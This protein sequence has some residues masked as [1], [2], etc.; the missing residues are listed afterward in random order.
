[1]ATDR[2]AGLGSIRWSGSTRNDPGTKSESTMD[3]VEPIDRNGRIITFYS[4]KGGVGRTMALANV[5][6][7]LASTGR[8]VLTV[9]WDLE[10]PGLHRYFAPFLVDKRLTESPGVIDAVR[11]FART[12]TRPDGDGVRSLRPEDVRVAAQIQRY[13]SSLERYE[14]PGGGS[15]DFVPPGR[16]DRTYS[17][18]VSTFNWDDFYERFDG[19]AY[20]DALAEDMR[21]NYDVT[22]IDS[23]TGLSDN[24]GI[25]TVQLPDAVVNYFTSEARPSRPR[26]ASNAARPGTACTPHRYQA[27]DETLADRALSAAVECSPTLTVGRY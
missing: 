14:F 9:D 7:I 3:I 26:G 18:S 13:A 15:I 11:D 22:L 19:A 21:R 8:R 4:F 10:S 16:Q 12:G 17:Q 25:C 23:R 1:M 2:R 20:L 5:A 27:V 24:A 6:W